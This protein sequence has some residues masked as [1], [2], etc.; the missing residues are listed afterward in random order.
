M[1]AAAP[2]RW[3]APNYASFTGTDATP[4]QQTFQSL[5]T[6][7]EKINNSVTIASGTGVTSLT[8]TANQITVSASTG[9]VTLSLPTNVTLVGGITVGGNVALTANS[10]RISQNSTS[11]WSGDA[12]AGFGKLEYHSNRWYINAGSDSTEIV[13]F[14]RGSSSVATINNAGTLTAYTGTRSVTLG[15]W[16]TDAAWAGVQGGNGYLLLGHS[17]DTSMYLRTSGGGDVYIGGANTNTIRVGSGGAQ[18][19]GTLQVSNYVAAGGTGN[20]DTGSVSC[21]GWFRAYDSTGLYFQ[22]YGGG[23]HMT[24]ST[25]IRSYNNKNVYMS[26]E[27]RVGGVFSANAQRYR[28]SYGGISFGN[29]GALNNW[30]GIEW[31]APYSQT[32]MIGQIGAAGYS[33]MYYNNNT[34]SWLFNYGTMVI[35]SDVRYKRDIHPLNIGLNFIKELE[36][37]S[38]LKLTESPDDDPEATQSGYY[39]G[40]TAQNVRAA[41]DV[42]GETRDVR[43]H[44]IGGPNMG[45]VACT[46]DAVYDRQFIGLSEFIGP[47]VLAIKELE[48]R[49]SQLEGTV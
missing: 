32:L 35:P 9:A 24:D 19:T 47:I 40:F 33:G 8:G 11:T 27:V 38:Y 15:A 23:W 3:A 1:T 7:L 10:T 34:W 16:T 6:Y 37:I 2:D 31:Q 17:S 13:N 20:T 36:P 41:L 46:E 48:Q 4:L 43:I 42:C 39:Y 44:D 12:G 28:G 18:I 49:V 26:H 22:S 14:R 30:D 45:L 21:N 25:W 29:N 5:S